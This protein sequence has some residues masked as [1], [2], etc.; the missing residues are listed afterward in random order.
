MNSFTEFIVK[1]SNLTQFLLEG[2]R[3]GVDSWFDVS[4]VPPL[5][6]KPGFQKPW[7]WDLPCRNSKKK[8]ILKRKVP[9]NLIK[10]VWMDRYFPNHE[11]MY[12]SLQTLIL[13][14]I[15]KMKV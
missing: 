14:L 7:E 11:T 9:L 13:L 10:L 4:N 5:L 12:F 15:I 2:L 8:R 1:C 3:P 6:L